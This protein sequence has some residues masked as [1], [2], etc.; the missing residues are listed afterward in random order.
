MAMKITEECISCGA[1]EPE[2]PVNAICEGEEIYEIDGKAC[3]ECKGHH[4]KPTCVEVC[5]VDCIPLNPEYEETHEELM[6][7]YRRLTGETA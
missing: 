3:V 4:D 6:E 2:C 1:C 7:K 5:P